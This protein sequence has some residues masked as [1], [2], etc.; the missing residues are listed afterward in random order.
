M[1]DRVTFLAGTLTLEGILERPD[2]AAPWGG[3]V[4]CHPHPLHGGTMHNNVVSRVTP[5]LAQAGLAVLRFNFRGVGKSEGQH[6]SGAGERNDV[7][8]ALGYV[9]AA[10][11]MA[12]KPLF[13]IGYSFGA[14][15]VARAA[16]GDARVT[17]V[18]CIALPAGFPGFD[19]FPELHA[20]TT[21]RLFLHGTADTLC[22]APAVRELVG[23][24][25]EPKHLILLPDADHVFHGREPELAG[26][27]LG[28][29]ASFR[30][31]A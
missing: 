18:A 27:L 9:A 23:A 6:E 10:E 28:F 2:G 22:P 17:A 24:L 13:A 3:A 16:C 31:A 26:H 20:C 12:D 30:P 14:A 25:P 1:I 21:P 7:R 5:L 4:F 11:G 29:F 19:D 15:V 8:G